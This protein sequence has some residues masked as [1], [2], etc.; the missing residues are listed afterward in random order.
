MVWRGR[1]IHLQVGH[2]SRLSAL[3]V[4]LLDMV[5]RGL[6]NVLLRISGQIVLLVLRDMEIPGLPAVL[7]RMSRHRVLLW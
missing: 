6:S 3:D 2:T 5:V 1:V 4:A 7:L